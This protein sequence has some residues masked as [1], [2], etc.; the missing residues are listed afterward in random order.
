MLISV[1]SRKGIV[2]RIQVIWACSIRLKI[3]LEITFLNPSLFFSNQMD[4]TRCSK[5]LMVD[6]TVQENSF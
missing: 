6:D 3:Y 5:A 1:N 2:N 4:T